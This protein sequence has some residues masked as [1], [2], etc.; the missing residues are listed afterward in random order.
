[1][2]PQ[3]L[4]L[5]P[6]LLDRLGPI[7]FSIREGDT[8]P[9]NLSLGQMLDSTWPPWFTDCLG[10]FRLLFTLDISN[11]TG[12]RDRWCPEF[13]NQRWIKPMGMGLERLMSEVETEPIGVQ[14][15]FILDRWEDALRRAQEVVAGSHQI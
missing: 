11:L 8:E 12:I 5:T 9:M 6:L 3:S 4:I 14:K 2:Q 7:L 15:R 10:Y 1:M 13:L